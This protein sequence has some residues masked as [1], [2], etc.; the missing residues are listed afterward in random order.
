MAIKNPGLSARIPALLKLFPDARV[1]HIYRNPYDVFLSMRHLFKSVLPRSQ[2]QKID[3]HEID[4]YVLRFYVQ[5]MQRFMADR[6]LIPPEN[7][8]EVQ[9]EA[10]EATPIEQMQRI[11]IGLRLPDFDK[12]EPLL[13]AYL[14]SIAGY[15][16][17][18]YHLHNDVIAQ[19]NAHWQF[20]FDAWGYPRL[21]PN[22]SA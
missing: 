6:A 16:K 5:L 2:V 4:A 7:F 20:A 17:N 21:E 19:V 18:A 8:V 14:A 15:K 9:F 11:Y 22:Q 13:R 12:V 10:L 1:I 3:A